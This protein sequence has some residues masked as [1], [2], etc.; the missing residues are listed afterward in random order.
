M[1][2]QN[3][4]EGFKVIFKGLQVSQTPSALFQ[5]P[6]LLPRPPLTP[7]CYLIL[8]A[9]AFQGKRSQA[10]PGSFILESSNRLFCK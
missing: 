8:K 7:H 4:T 10:G 5:S 2:C 3:L 9:M 6:V 1:D